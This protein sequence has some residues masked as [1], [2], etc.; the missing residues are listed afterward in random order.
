MEGRS[1]V[2]AGVQDGTRIDRIRRGTE[3]RRRNRRRY[4]EQLMVMPLS[5]EI[6][7]GLADLYSQSALNDIMIPACIRLRV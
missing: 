3:S 1:D 2:T 5:L 6:L 4:K 7:Y